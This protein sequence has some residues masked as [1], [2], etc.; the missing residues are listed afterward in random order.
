VTFK[1]IVFQQ[2]IV[3]IDRLPTRDS[4]PNPLVLSGI[5]G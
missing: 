1:Q 3:G 2:W 5:K 4:W